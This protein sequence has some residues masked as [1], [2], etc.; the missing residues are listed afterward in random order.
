MQQ[1][2]NNAPPV[3][4]MP[5]MPQTPPVMPA[6]FTPAPVKPPRD[7]SFNE[8]VFAL[9]SL[10]LG[11]IFCRSFSPINKPFYSLI[12][13]VLL[14][15][16]TTIFLIIKKAKFGKAAIAVAASGLGVSLSL[17]ISANAVIHFFAFLYAIAAYCYYVYA[18]FVN[19]LEGGFSSLILI[20]FLKAVFV[21]PFLA[22]GGLFRAIFSRKDGKLGKNIGKAL[23]GLV[24]AVVPTVTILSLLWYDNDFKN[25]LSGIFNFN[26]LNVFSH[27]LSIAIG[28]PVAMYIFGLFIAS[29]DGS[30]KSGLTAEKCRNAAKD[31]AIAPAVTAFAA[32]LPILF[33]YTLFFVSQFKY[34]VSGFVGVLPDEVSYANYAREG[35]FQ[36][37]IVCFINLVILILVNLLI[38]RNSK[39]GSLPLKILS[40]IFSVYTLV[41]AST[42]VAKMVLYINRYGLTPKR[43]YATWF[44]AVLSLIFIAMLIKQFVPKFKVIPTA[45]IITVVMFFALGVCGTDSIIAKYNVNAY[46]NGDLATVDVDALEEL[47]DAA[48]PELINLEQNLNKIE[49]PTDEQ[50]ALEFRINGIISRY[51]ANSF[52][53]SWQGITLPSL[54]AESSTKE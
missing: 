49:N 24:M 34:Y 16:V 36:L 46:L 10:I 26:P 6:P 29:N 50:D 4:P 45:V 47:G 28:I 12:F 38:K 48:I 15:T 32:A 35:F 9:I 40:V 27:I 54:L 18:A 3:A 41:L 53:D 7:Y 2:Y 51:K 25:L 22:F 5:Q 33:I 1:Q 21:T 43:V 31:A 42:A 8:A 11:Y 14:Y 37:C 23:L 44:M 13:I 20:D 19:R 30:S 39:G 17:F 52:D